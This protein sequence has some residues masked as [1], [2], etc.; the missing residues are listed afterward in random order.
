MKTLDIYAKEWL[1]EENANSYFAGLIT[2]DKGTDK[3]KVYLMPFQYGY[4]S[5]YEQEAIR[6]LT[7]FNKISANYGSSL[8]SYCSEN[9]IKFSSNIVFKCRLKDL[10]DIKV[11]Y[12]QNILK[13]L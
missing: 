12:N 4:G 11:Q 10:K 3:E 1:D 13:H 2:L 7:E 5:T 9:S 6:L 8:F